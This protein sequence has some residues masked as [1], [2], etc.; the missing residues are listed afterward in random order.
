MTSPAH[1]GPVAGQG[2]GLGVGV[3]AGNAVGTAVGVGE[4]LVKGAAAPFNPTKRV[5][6]RW[7]TE[8]TS[9]GRRIQ[10]P[11]DVLVDAQGRPIKDRFK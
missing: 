3:V 2:V 5:V 11:V 1:P 7:R 6:R 9:D 4:G 10:V 8:I